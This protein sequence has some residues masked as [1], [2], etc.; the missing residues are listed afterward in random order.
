MTELVGGDLGEVGEGLV[1]AAA[2]PAV[3]EDDVAVEDP[4]ERGAVHDHRLRRAPEE[5]AHPED[6]AAV[7]G[8]IHGAVGIA[9][10]HRVDA[11]VTHAGGGRDAAVRVAEVGL[12]IVAPGGFTLADLVE[13][14][15]RRSRLAG[16]V[17]V[18]RDRRAAVRLEPA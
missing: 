11:V 3:V 7:D 15:R 16:G 4:H 2:L 17:D 18:H 6:P 1:E 8:R 9:E 10:A 12:G 14:L 5:A 13:A